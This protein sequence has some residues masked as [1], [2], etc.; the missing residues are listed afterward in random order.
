[1]KR[2]P[3]NA[4]SKRK[5]FGILCTLSLLPVSV[6]VTI[7]AHRFSESRTAVGESNVSA[8]DDGTFE[9]VWVDNDVRVDGKKGM[10]IHARFVVRNSL[11]LE[12]RIVAQFYRKNGIQLS[13]EKGGYRNGVNQVVTFENFKPRYNVSRYSDKTLFIPYSA[14]NLTTPGEYE[15]KFILFLER[16]VEGG[17]VVAHSEDFNFT[18][19]KS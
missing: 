11:G 19:K 4:A 12:C 15:L 17:R 9:Q 18:F 2:L 5:L 1:M 3:S 10:R 13:S 16:M 14:F 6:P 7:G 8:V